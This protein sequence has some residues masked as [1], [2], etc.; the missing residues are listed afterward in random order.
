[1]SRYQLLEAFLRAI[2]GNKATFSTGQGWEAAIA[3]KKENA[4]IRDLMKIYHRFGCHNIYMHIMEAGCHTGTHWIR[5]MRATLAN[6]LYQD[7][8]ERFQNQKTANKSLNWVDQGCKYQEWAGS[9]VKHPI[10]GL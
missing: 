1:M 7:F 8:P 5:D 6:K 9:S 10:L 2:R 4:D 3:K